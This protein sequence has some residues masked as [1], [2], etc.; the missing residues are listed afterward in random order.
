MA[1][2][3]GLGWAKPVMCTT[4]QS[5]SCLSMFLSNKKYY[6]WNHIEGDVWEIKEPTSLENIADW[7]GKVG[8]GSLRTRHI[9][10]RR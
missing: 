2:A 3:H 7:M 5:G 6:L 8:V 10:Q 9:P 1:K 4:R